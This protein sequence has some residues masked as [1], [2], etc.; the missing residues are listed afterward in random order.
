MSFYQAKS[1]FDKA[2]QHLRDQEGKI[3]YDEFEERKGLYSGLSYLAHSLVD[4][5]S[6]LNTIKRKLDR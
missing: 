2:S 6:Q 1:C 5:E 4:M 3:N